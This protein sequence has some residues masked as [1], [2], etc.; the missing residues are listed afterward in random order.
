MRLEKNAC[1]MFL[2]IQVRWR[3]EKLILII[4]RRYTVILFK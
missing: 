1:G 4:L 2:S 3:T